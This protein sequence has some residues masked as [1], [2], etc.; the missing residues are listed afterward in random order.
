MVRKEKMAQIVLERKENIYCVKSEGT[1]L[2]DLLS[3]E[4]EVDLVCINEVDSKK[5]EDFSIYAKYH[6][7]FIPINKMKQKNTFRNLG[8]Y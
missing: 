7:E 4:R 3:S 2:E 5:L 6:E 8:V 1:I